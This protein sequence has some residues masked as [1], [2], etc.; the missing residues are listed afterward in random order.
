MGNWTTDGFQP[1]MDML[2]GF[3]EGM[4]HKIEKH[5]REVRIIY[6]SQIVGIL[7]CTVGKKLSIFLFSLLLKIQ[8]IKKY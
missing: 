6:C 4:P 5:V 3:L 7:K 1:Y 8:H 2:F